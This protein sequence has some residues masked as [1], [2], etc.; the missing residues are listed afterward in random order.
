MTG[1]AG[2]ND[3]Q[4]NV[5]ATF[6]EIV[7]GLERDGVGT[8]WPEDQ[9]ATGQ[10]TAESAAASEEARPVEPAGASWRGSDKEWDWTLGSED[11]HYVPPEPPP[12]PRPRPATVAAFVLLLIGAFLLAVPGLIGLDPRVATPLALISLTSGVGWLVLRMRQGPPPSH[13]DTNGAQL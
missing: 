7:A 4:E 10:E 11:E 8:R 5:D 3:G 6:A 2:N 1:R 13:D 9:P 12:F